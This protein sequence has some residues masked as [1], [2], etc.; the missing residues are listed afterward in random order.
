MEW[1]AIAKTAGLSD[2]GRSEAIRYLLAK[3]FIEFTSQTTQIIALTIAGVELADQL[4]TRLVGPRPDDPLPTSA[5]DIRTHLAYWQ[6]R[7]FNGEPQSNWWYQVQARIDALR[8]AEQRFMPGAGQTITA[9]FAG[10]NARL[11]VNSTDQSINA[12]IAE[13]TS[14]NRLADS[15]LAPAAP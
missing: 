1:V 9:H 5:E 8:H 12:V 13:R 3:G 15:D 2:E 7:Q 14:R 6:G 10:P 11:N 4:I